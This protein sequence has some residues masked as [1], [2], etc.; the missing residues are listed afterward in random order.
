MMMRQMENSSNI[1]A[2]SKMR[3]EQQSALKGLKM[4]D[5]DA[6]AVVAQLGKDLTSQT[7]LQDVRDFWKDSLQTTMMSSENRGST[8][9]GRQEDQSPL[10]HEEGT[11]KIFTTESKLKSKF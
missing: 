3:G 9:L 11:N 7:V 4:S 2:N 1:E 6:A 5:G 8:A 10:A